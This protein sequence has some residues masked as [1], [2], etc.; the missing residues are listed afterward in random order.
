MKTPFAI[1]S[2]VIVLACASLAAVAG[3]ADD[4][5]TS[6]GKS[7]AQGCESAVTAAIHKARGKG[8]QQVLFVAPKR[9]VPH[10]VPP[11]A[12]I[13]GEGRYQGAGA[14]MPFT[15]SC[16]L[17]PQTH[18]TTGVI[19]KE[20]GEPVR[21]AEKPWQADL[22]NL[23][24][25]VCEAGVATAIKDKYPRAVNV[26]LSSKSRQLKPAPGGH[27]YMHGQGS[28]DRAPGMNTSAFTYRCELE[29]VSG[30]FIS[31]QT[32]LVE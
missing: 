20:T 1:V 19:F 15:Y 14:A 8:V 6:G 7:A 17:D 30:K 5:A 2:W 18:E 16:T 23:S 26:V 21:A 11:E 13:S 4:A 29:S 28:V 32:D 3:P 22:T 27:T 25:E 9:A 31:A 10:A 24:P 12:T